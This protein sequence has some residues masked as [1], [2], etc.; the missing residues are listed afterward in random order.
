MPFPPRVSRT[1][2]GASGMYTLLEEDVS[3]EAPTPAATPTA[4]PNSATTPAV[5]NNARATTLSL[6]SRVPLQRVIT[7]PPQPLAGT[8]PQAGPATAR[9]TVGF[10]AGCVKAP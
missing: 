2:L 9:L 7:V 8:H 1:R 4:L 6:G 10:R 3:G 5:A